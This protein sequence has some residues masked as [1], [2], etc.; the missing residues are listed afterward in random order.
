MYKIDKSPVNVLIKDNYDLKKTIKH[1][2]L[3]KVAKFFFFN[4]VKNSVEYALSNTLV[5]LNL[6]RPLILNTK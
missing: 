6:Y 1:G 5:K 3:F 2:L 4:V